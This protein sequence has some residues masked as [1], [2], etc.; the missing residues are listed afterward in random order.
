M[1]SAR[2]TAQHFCAHCS[3]LQQIVVETTP[4]NSQHNLTRNKGVQ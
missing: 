4:A 2:E 3:I 1:L